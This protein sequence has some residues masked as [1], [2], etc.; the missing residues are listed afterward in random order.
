M[1]IIPAIDV[2]RGKCV[3]LDQGN[4]E[5]A[6]V[7]DHDPVAMAQR[8]A[9]AGARMIHVVDLDAA[10]A[11]GAG[12]RPL[13]REIVRAISIPVQFG[14]GLRTATAVR[15]VLALGIAT[16]V[17]GTM[18]VEQPDALAEIV[19]RHRSDP[20]AVPIHPKKRAE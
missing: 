4:R 6:T 5:S 9:A 15:E 20:N 18:A 11:D 3:R 8:F 17:V 12:N 1:V 7:Y 2:R 13:L 14:G 19:N 16:A 10:F